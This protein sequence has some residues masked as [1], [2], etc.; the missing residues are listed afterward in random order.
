MYDTE[1]L[2]WLLVVPVLIAV[3]VSKVGASVICR[4]HRKAGLVALNS[5]APFAFA[6]TGFL[7]SGP[8]LGG[9]AGNSMALS[10]VVLSAISMAE[11]RG[12]IG[13]STWKVLAQN[14]AL[15]VDREIDQASLLTGF[16]AFCAAPL[17]LVLFVPLLKLV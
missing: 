10:G 13:P 1:G 16:A 5:S 9:A 8:S 14:P 15:N 17:L 2:Q 11:L 7:V 3:L 4:N 6:C 12:R